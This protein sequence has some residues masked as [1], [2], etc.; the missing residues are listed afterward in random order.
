MSKVLILFSLFFLFSCSESSKEE[1][2]FKNCVKDAIKK[3]KWSESQGV[4]ACELV[5]KNSP[6]KF[7]YYKG[8][9]WSKK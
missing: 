9:V 1:K 2:Y 5:K 3:M 6:N 8:K 4:T 7:K